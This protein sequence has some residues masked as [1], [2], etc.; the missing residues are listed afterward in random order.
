MRGQT[1]RG[2]SKDSRFYACLALHL[3]EAR[4]SV[5]CSCPGVAA[6]RRSC[7]DVFPAS[8]KQP[9]CFVSSR[10]QVFQTSEALGRKPFTR[11]PVWWRV[12]IDGRRPILRDCREPADHVPPPGRPTFCLSSIFMAKCWP[13][14]LCLTS[15]TRPKEPVPKVFRRS[16]WS[17][18][19]VCWRKWGWVEAVSIIHQYES[20][21]HH[22]YRG[23]HHLHRGMHHLYRGIHTRTSGMGS[24]SVP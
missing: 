11:N 20:Y 6:R 23:M 3:P 17:N 1:T 18:A 21:I 12:F 8:N 7:C 5:S 22:L 10:I 9:F 13:V 24:K 16:K 14:S 4:L 19:A 2:A 15:M